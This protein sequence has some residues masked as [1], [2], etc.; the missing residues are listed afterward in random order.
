MARILLIDDDG[1]LL[2][3]LSL[4]LEDAGHEVE[5]ADDGQAGLER[6]RAWQPEIVVSD[7]NMPR[8]DG[9]SLCR[10]LREAGATVPL[11]L[12]TSRDSEIDEALG[13][14]LGADDY[15]TKPFRMRV[16][17]ARVNA[18]LRRESLR[19]SSEPTTTDVQRLGALE[20]DAERLEMRYDSTLLVVTVTEFR[21]I[22]AL[23]SRPGVVL[24]RARLLEQ[25]R[26]DDSVVA[27]RLVDTYIRRMRRKFE[28]IDENFEEIETVV[29]AGYRW[30]G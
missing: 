30:R 1:P 29:G 5:V 11:I 4:S 2:D 12:L 28:A 21:M 15:V 20:L 16:L 7:I 6:F 23:A 17:L 14:E 3:M 18:L 24:S 8:L 13:L 10:Q 26:G 25:M 27:E 9:F 22:E 19:A